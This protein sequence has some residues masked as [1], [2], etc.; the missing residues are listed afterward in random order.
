MKIKKAIGWTIILNIIPVFLVICGIGQ[1]TNESLWSW[2]LGG[3]AVN[4][5]IACLCGIVSFA[6][7]CITD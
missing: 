3:W 2:Y 4:M 1:N 7:W 6:F 5:I